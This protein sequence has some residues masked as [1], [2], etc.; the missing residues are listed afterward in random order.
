MRFKNVIGIL[1]GFFIC[2]FQSNVQAQQHGMVIYECGYLNVPENTQSIL[3]K[4]PTEKILRFNG[5]SVS[6]GSGS[7]FKAYLNQVWFLDSYKGY[8]TFEFPDTGFVMRRTVADFTQVQNEWL[9]VEYAESTDETKIIAGLTSTRYRVKYIEF[10]EVYDIWCA[11]DFPGTYN[12]VV[13]GLPGMPVEFQVPDKNSSMV[14]TYKAMVYNNDL[15]A[16][17][18]FII[19]SQFTDIT[20]EQLQRYLVNLDQEINTAP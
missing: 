19:P 17:Q 2:A 6:M 7:A 18:F 20:F 11:L 12:F 10:D 16:D 13:K 15:P 4:L 14:Y 9:T 5:D 8:L 1:I 3:H